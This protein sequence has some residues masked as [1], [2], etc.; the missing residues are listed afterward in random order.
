MH[1]QAA[2]AHADM[3]LVKWK[4]SKL[5]DLKIKS[6]LARRTNPVCEE[7]KKVEAWK[8]LLGIWQPV[9]SAGW[10]NAKFCAHPGR[11]NLRW[12]EDCWFVGWLRVTLGLFW[13]SWRE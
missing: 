8:G 10:G 6:K 9:S 11:L 7:R 2:A 1:V 13:R 4:S 12:F 3:L 5:Q